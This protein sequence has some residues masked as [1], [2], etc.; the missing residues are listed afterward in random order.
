MRP[1]TSLCELAT[2]TP[3]GHAASRQYP[4]ITSSGRSAAWTPAR[5][6]TFCGLL[7]RM[8]SVLGAAR[9][10]CTEFAYWAIRARVRLDRPPRHAS[11]DVSSSAGRPMG[12]DPWAARFPWFGSGSLS[13]RWGLRA[14]PPQGRRTLSKSSSHPLS[15]LLVL[16][17]E[18]QQLHCRSI[19][20]ALMTRLLWL[21]VLSYQNRSSS[22]YDH[23]R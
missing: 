2:G 4:R 22:N 17:V 6:R 13:W 14:R 9:V 11:F 19:Y 18:V 23:L 8:C 20:R 3:A 7:A 12:R 16:M 1:H 15:V 21:G 10:R 5:A